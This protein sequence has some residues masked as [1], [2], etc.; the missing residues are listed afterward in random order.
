M[1]TAVDI[2]VADECWVAVALLTR[3]HPEKTSFSSGEILKR[4]AQEHI[5]ATGRPG[6]QAHIH[7]HIVANRPPSTARYRMTYRLDDGTF[8]LYRPGDDCHP[9]RSGKTHPLRSELPPGYHAL[10]DWYEDI[11]CRGEKP[12]S[13]EEDPILSLRGLGKELWLNVDPDTWVNDL[14]SG[15]L[16]SPPVAERGASRADALKSA[17]ADREA[18]RVWLRIVQHQQCEFRTHTNL[19]FTYQVDGDSGI[20]FFREG[21]RIERRLWRGEL[22]AALKSP[23]TKPGNLSRFQCPAYLFGLLTDPRINGGQD[24]I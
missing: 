21:R 24:G 8:R 19:P 11:Y 16:D 22:E 2:K 4:I 10:L 12:V 23:L 14:R 15:W 5:H 13:L 7:Q 17:L 9:D 20:W 6:L 1:R 3:E 18:E